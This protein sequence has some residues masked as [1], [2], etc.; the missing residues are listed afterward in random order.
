MIAKGTL[1]LILAPLIFC[2]LFTAM[3]L[4]TKLFTILILSLLS[5]LITIFFIVFFR[6][7]EHEIGNGIVAP[8]DGKIIE[9]QRAEKITK[10]SIFM[11]LWNAHVNSAPLDC[12]V[13][14]IVRKQGKHYSAY[15]KEAVGNERVEYELET[16]IGIVKLAQVAGSF[17][18]K[19]ICWVKENDALKKGQ[20]LGMIR[21]G[22]R[23]E[24]YLP[25]ER[26]DLKI[27]L[28]DKVLAGKTTIGLIK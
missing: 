24:L 20:R 4:Y 17:A 28:G 18:R 8:A 9:L 27:K 25:T 26:I 21:F 3:F 19:I 15:K 5:S 7:V 6:D 13:I 11:S 12:K 22:S 23:V 16:D 1:H 14:K 2:A 10:I